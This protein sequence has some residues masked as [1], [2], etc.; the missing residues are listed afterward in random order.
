[1][2]ANREYRFLSPS[3]VYRKTDRQIMKLNGVGLV[4]NPALHLTALAR[5]ESSMG[6]TTDI[7]ARL[8]T[9]LG[10]PANA[11]EDAIFAAVEALT[12][13][14]TAETTDPARFVPVEAVRDLLRDHNAQRADMALSQ[15][16]SKVDDAMRRGY[17]TPAMR[18][19]AEALCA[20]DEASFD[21]F[22][23]GAV[24]QFANL[25]KPVLPARPP[26]ASEPTR[27]SAAA[28]AICEQLGLPG[29]RLSE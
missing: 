26:V 8:A 4:H 28:A 20:R 15:A 12:G 25:A 23:R 7:L 2:I 21:C 13:A 6:K 17:L 19:W 18:G 29:D 9:V 3:F 1:M 27:N 14:A 11:D 16:K 5:E 10:L 24:P 22:I